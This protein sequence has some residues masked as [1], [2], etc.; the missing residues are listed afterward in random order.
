MRTLPRSVL[1]V[2][3]IAVCIGCGR[4][5][6][7]VPPASDQSPPDVRLTVVYVPPG[8]ADP[9]T[10]LATP[11]D[12]VVYVDGRADRQ[13]HVSF[14]A[15]DPEGMKQLWLG[16]ARLTTVGAGLDSKR[17]P[18]EPLTETCPVEVLAGVWRAPR[19]DPGT[20]V[21][22]SVSAQ[23]WAGKHAATSSVTVRLR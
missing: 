13:V 14:W 23:N 3:G 12:S 2:V 6:C 1:A 18:V 11:A 17:M 4:S 15:R 10:L 8:A 5:D 21:T 16:A 7:L 9:D 20:S 22:L 19:L